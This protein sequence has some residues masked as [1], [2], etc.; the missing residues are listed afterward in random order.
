MDSNEGF[1]VARDRELGI[2]FFLFLGWG[3]GV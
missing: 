1:G 3:G 2:V